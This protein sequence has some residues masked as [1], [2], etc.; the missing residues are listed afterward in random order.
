[1]MTPMRTPPSRAH[2]ELVDLLSRFGAVKREI[3]A[4]EDTK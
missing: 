2:A 3:G 4:Q 1:M